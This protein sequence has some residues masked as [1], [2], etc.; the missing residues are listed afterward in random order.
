MPAPLP[1]TA[2]LADRL[3]QMAAAPTVDEQELQRIAQVANRMFSTDAASAHAILG[4]VATLR[5]DV[6]EAK[7]RYSLAIPLGDSA[8]ILCDYADSLTFLGQ[9]DDAFDAAQAAFERAPDNVT[10]LRRHGE[11]RAPSATRKPKHRTI[12]HRARHVLR[13]FACFRIDG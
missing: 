4:R 1:K 13:H 2:E 6:E 3:Q 5:W 8:P 12:D 10:V 7:R 9:I 11:T